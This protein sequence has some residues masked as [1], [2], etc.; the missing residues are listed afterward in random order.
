MPAINRYFISDLHLSSKKLYDKGCSWFKKTEHEPRL[1]NFIDENILGKTNIK[2]VV[3][4]GDIFNTWI[5]PAAE[6]PPSYDE[7]FN[8][9]K[10][11]LDRFKKIIKSGINLFYVNGNHDYDL[12]EDD[13][14]VAVP[15]IM[16]IKIYSSGLLH[17]EHGHLFD[18]IFNKPDYLCDPAFGRPIGYIISR[19]I[20]SFSTSGYSLLDL[21]TYLDDIV[22]AALTNQNIYET[23]IEGL[24]ER[25]GMN[26]DDVIKMPHGKELSIREAKSRYR[27]LGEKYSSSEFV[28]E[29]W[30]RSSLGWHADK[31]CHTN[32]INVVIFGHSHKALIDKDFFLVKDRIYANTGS[33]CK[34]NAY[35][36]KVEKNKTTK[37]TLLKIDP[38]GKIKKRTSKS[39]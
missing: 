20:T 22:E 17:A 21:P 15:G 32:D 26:D 36:V 5:C 16:P 24:A 3:L 27:K 29:L 12:K 2:D 4:L 18:D 14:R 9:N 1:I 38:D 37:V 35:C 13:I 8:A 11:I 31:M 19:L 39:L 28:R 23:I 34:K 33:W 25:A 6:E 7:I 30:D 10:K